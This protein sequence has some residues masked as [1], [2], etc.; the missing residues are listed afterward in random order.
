VFL[1]K[2]PFLE[3]LDTLMMEGNVLFPAL[4]ATQHNA[5]EK[6]A[7]CPNFPKAGGT[8]SVN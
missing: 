6:V 5:K 7:E 1:N 3:I 8:E 4:K 2:N